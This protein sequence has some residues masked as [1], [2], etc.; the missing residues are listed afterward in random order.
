MLP[1]NERK[2]I[3]AGFSKQELAGLEYDWKFWG[4]PKQQLP[5][6]THWNIWI[7][8]A[9]RGFGKTRTGSEAIRRLVDQKQ[10]S[11]IALIGST[12]ADTR[13][14]ML[15]GASGL[16]NVFP[17]HQR[18]KFEP[19]KRKVTFH[20][21]AVAWLYAAEFEDRLRGPQHD[22]VWCD[23][24]CAWRDV[25]TWDMAQMG[26]R[27]GKRPISIVTTTPKPTLWVR[28]MIKRSR[29][30]NSPVILTTG[31]TF[32]N[33]SNLASNFFE[34]VIS[35]YEG[36]R[37][38]AQEIYAQVLEDVE[39]A[40]WNVDMI[41]RS[42]VREI[43]QMRRIVVAIDPANGS[44]E[45][46]DHTGIIVAGLG[47]DKHGYILADYSVKGTPLQ[48]ATVAI[49]AYRTW[50]ADRVIAEVNNAGEMIEQSLRTVDAN[51]PYKAVR[52]SKGKATRAE[53][54]S[55]MYERKII[56]HY[57][58]FPELEEEMTT[59]DP[60][61]KHE[62]PDRMDAMVWALTELMLG[63]SFRRDFSM[64]PTG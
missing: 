51:V 53:P 22:V 41:D 63:G 17:P 19:S 23:E 49:K 46:N 9:G 31:S 29:E 6:G 38:G 27:L 36:S 20:N 64:L 60:T 43:P 55:A 44:G 54:I 30:P 50:K 32:E 14:V 34:Q 59:W 8:C 15:E 52:A 56:H 37:L 62:S 18:P 1:E 3:L 45:K 16:M 48:W 21:G 13:D 5:P 40:Y 58:A 39:G 42:R 57:G 2:R 26:L 7:L 24:I 35:R 61:K 12:A 10:A 4:R 47:V 33:R 28:N 11:R 25:G